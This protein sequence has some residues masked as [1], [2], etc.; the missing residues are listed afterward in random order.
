MP[1][2]WKDFDAAMR[3]LVG[4][5][6]VKHRLLDAYSHHLA[7]V[8][9]QDLPDALRGRFVALHAAMCEARPSYGL[10]AAEV[11]VRKMSERDAAQW[12]AAILEMFVTLA[13]ENVSQAGVRV[14][15]IGN[16]SELLQ[17]VLEVPAFLRRA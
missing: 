9:D 1:H 12:A 6:P 7:Q 16:A 5:G 14:L 11:S 8:R 10:T 15:E 17:D 13:A 3:A 4:T 2:P